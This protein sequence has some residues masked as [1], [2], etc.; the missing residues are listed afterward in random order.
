MTDSVSTLSIGLECWQR[1]LLV[2]LPL[3]TAHS[4]VLYLSFVCGGHGH[5]HICGYC[6]NSLRKVVLPSNMLLVFAI[7]NRE[8][9]FHSCILARHNR[10]YHMTTWWAYR[11]ILFI[12]VSY[13]RLNQL[14]VHT[15]KSLPFWSR[16]R[17]EEFSRLRY[18]NFTL[19]SLINSTT[20]ISH[21]I[22][23]IRQDVVRILN[24]IK[25][26]ASRYASMSI[27]NKFKGFI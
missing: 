11:I 7:C 23:K 6:S 26:G 20:V 13:N 19:F 9:Q 2:E 15:R 3:Q 16:T 8:W 27:L 5:D 12:R 24:Q 4:F 25:A 1:H 21:F 14:A 18:N 10:G 22:K 17:H